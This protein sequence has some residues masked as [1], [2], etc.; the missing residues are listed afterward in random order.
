MIKRKLFLTLLLSYFTFFIAGAQV[1]FNGAMQSANIAVC[2]GSSEALEVDITFTVPTNN[3]ATVTAELGQG[4]EYD[5]G[6]AVVNSQPA[7]AFS[8]TPL[9]VASDPN[10]P[11]FTITGTG[12]SI[13][14][15]DRLTFT[16]N[17]KATCGAYTYA[18]GVSGNNFRDKIIVAVDGDS[19]E[20]ETDQYAVQFPNL[21]LTAP[22]P[23]NNSNLLDDIQR[24]FTVT[25]GSQDEAAKVYI[26][27]AY[28]NAKY[29]Q[30]PGAATLEVD[31]GSGF[32]ALTPVNVN[33]GTA[34]YVLE[35]T[36]LGADGL[37]TNGEAITLRESFKL[38]D[39]NLETNYIAGWGCDV[40]DLCQEVAGQSI[41]TM[42][43]GT[44][45]FSG[46]TFDRTNYTNICSDYTLTL[47]YKN[48]GTGASMGGMYDLNLIFAGNAIGRGFYVHSFSG[49]NIN[50]NALTNTFSGTYANGGIDVKL[51]NLFSTDPDGP[52][53]LD[54][55]DGDGYY[56]DLPAGATVDLVTTVTLSSDTPTCSYAIN[57]WINI[58][59][60]KFNT[61]CG[62]SQEISNNGTA[63]ARY[64]RTA[65]SSASYLPPNIE[66]GVAFSGRIGVNAY[67]YNTYTSGNTRYV[68]EIELPTGMSL[69]NIQW[70]DGQ[71]PSTNQPVSPGSVT[72]NGN[73]VT[74]VSPSN[75]RGHITFDAL[76]TCQSGTTSVDITHT[77]HQVADYVNYP[78]CVS[79]GANLV[80][81]SHS[82]VVVGCG[83]CPGGGA[84]TGVPVVERADNSLGWTDKT[85]TTIQDRNNIS[86][87]DLRKAMYLDEFFVETTATQNGVAANLGARFVVAKNL[88][89]NNGLTPLSADVEIIRGGATIATGTV[90]S[91]TSNFSTATDQVIDWDFT[92]VLPAGGLLN[93]DKMKIITRYQVT[94]GRYSYIDE[95]SGKEWYVY[96]SDSPSGAPVWDGNHVYCLKLVPEVYLMG[97][98]KLNA[99]NYWRA[100]ACTSVN[101]GSNLSYV[102]R[103]FN[104]GGLQY[105]NEYRPGMKLNKFYFELPKTLTLNSITYIRQDPLESSQPLTLESS[106][107]MGDHF[108]NVYTI[109]DDLGHINTTVVNNYGAWIRANVTPTC[110]T[111]AN[112][113]DYD[114]IKTYFDYTD[115]YYYAAKQATPPASLEFSQHLLRDREVVYTKKPAMTLVDQTGTVNLHGQT[116]EWVIRYNNPTPQ[117]AP[118]TWLALPAMPNLVI[119]SVT[120]MSDNTV[121]APIAYTGGNIYHLDD[122]GVPAGSALDYKINFTYTGCGDLDLPIQ[123]GWNCSDYPAS[124]DEYVCN[125]E[126]LDL[127][128]EPE[129]SVVE[130]QQLS[131]PSGNATL[132]DPY[133]PYVYKMQSSAAADLYDP[134][135]ELVSSPG[136]ALHGN[137]IELEYPAGSGNWETFTPA[138][139]GGVYTISALQHTALSA[140]GYLKGTTEAA[141]NEE[142]QV[143]LRFSVNTACDFVSG[144][145]FKVKVR[146]KNTCNNPA[147][148][149]SSGTTAPIIVVN[150]ATQPYTMNTVVNWV[151]PPVGH[152]CQAP[153]RVGVEQTIVGS[154]QPTGPDG[155]IE[156]IIPQ[157]YRYITGSYVPGA[158]APAAAGLLVSVLGN[159]DQ[160]LTLPV[161]AGLQTSTTIAYAFDIQE[162]SANPP[163]CGSY[164]LQVASRERISNLSCNGSPCT[165]SYMVTGQET[166][167]INV[168]KSDLELSVTNTSATRTVAGEDIT[169]EYTIENTA[170]V[171]LAS[172]TTVT[173]FDDKDNDNVFSAGDVVLATQLTTANVSAATPFNGTFTATGVNPANLCNVKIT[174]LPSDGCFCSV[175]PANVRFASLAGVAGD[176]FTVCANSMAM[177]MGVAST[178]YTS[179]AWSSTNASGLDYL[180][181]TD[182]ARPYFQYNGPA[183]TASLDIEYTLTVTRPDGC[184][185]TDRV[186]VTVNPA[187][188]VP[189]Y[190]V[191]HVNTCGV[192]GSITIVPQ[193]GC[194][195][196][197]DGASYSSNNTFTGLAQGSY[198]I[199]VRNANGC[200]VMTNAEVQ[201][202]SDC[203]GLSNAEDLDAD[204][205]G[206]LDADEGACMVSSDD[207]GDYF[208]EP[209]QSNEGEHN[210]GADFN[211]WKLHGEDII[212]VKPAANSSQPAHSGMQ[213]V[214]TDRTV[215]VYLYKD[216]E[217]NSTTFPSGKV[218]I[219]ASAWVRRHALTRGGTRMGGQVMPR[220]Q[221]VRVNSNTNNVLAVVATGNAVIMYEG[222][223]VKTMLQNVSLPVL[224]AGQHYRVRIEIIQNIDVD[225][226]GFCVS[227]DTDGDGIPDYLDLDSDGDG[228]ADAIEGDENVAAAQLDGN[229]RID[230]ANQGDVDNQGVPNLV[231][232]GGAAD[233]G[234]D[235][236]QGIG[237]SQDVAV[238]ACNIKTYNDI[239]QTPQG[240][241][242]DGNVLTN[243]EDVV[244]VVSAQCYDASGNPQNLPLGAATTVYGKDK[245]GA[246][247]EAGQITLNTDG[248]YTFVPTVDFVG[249]VPVNYTAKNAWFN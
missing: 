101:I 237:S 167:N 91:F 185:A 58:A 24:T 25:N 39:C 34:Q 193:A 230:V 68:T 20:K 83:S 136:L 169:V 33:G 155:K 126:Q 246:W 30:A 75:A 31:A 15:G 192:Q 114:R 57:D 153:A 35:N 28:G 49:I 215:P 113:A 21:L 233:D 124:P 156:I 81:D 208:D 170:A 182:V 123:G 7:G 86:A 26:S 89:N 2:D 85:M 46:V 103:R 45:N 204:N 202:D 172:A 80:C 47:H 11:T 127:T 244:D 184:I 8:I 135:F 56:D 206:I 138:L 161:P 150:G 144:K 120:R 145:S 218:T 227:A 9:D 212:V 27:V 176:D 17:R 29:F 151:T 69:S 96:N 19:Q 152:L 12:G 240:K 249:D 42:A 147:E 100:Q 10:R 99:S 105:Q 239:N 77:T 92:S 139:S 188:K 235:Q 158:N 6:L 187:P 16:F 146:G 219:S 181:A 43:S 180:S 48:T 205:D 117:A 231:N 88:D 160:L 41:V 110:A 44:P 13:N 3:P 73:T 196:S 134:T 234:A 247:V 183:L 111:S 40:A 23:V 173:L 116:D 238:N 106:T 79:L 132:C 38:K 226:M 67:L 82:F 63:V 223:W 242:V 62:T 157:G 71:W 131:V 97:T 197:I 207:A 222:V 195:Y 90:T 209:E 163:L 224:P 112:S 177:P 217:I 194:E 59:V 108:L 130:L 190:T 243:D 37:L 4:V 50:G 211:G 36:A 175:I 61:A 166:L 198:V 22:E 186:V 149:S 107:D 201:L 203:D 140:I 66:S 133:G 165:D 248:T 102:A 241:P 143:N 121:V 55:L 128:V 76:Y 84:T 18:S 53:G 109:P 129:P 32:V 148:G 199:Y 94:S 118:Y 87:Y 64:R 51:A 70:V 125:A 220:I 119:N 225:T 5:G 65:I 78:N 52:G 54:D 178:A 141:S 137:S 14:V 174:I 236:G 1:S 154:A 74:V 171:D 189:Q 214:R 229:D 245:N 142:R 179:Y 191:T 122:A 228:C 104:Q 98:R 60:V 95:N 159:G 72:T 232:A 115:Y 210:V 93:Q 164:A 216:L 221:V 162:D 168:E 213:Y 200:E